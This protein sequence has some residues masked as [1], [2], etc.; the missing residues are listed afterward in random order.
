MIHPI[1]TNISPITAL[2]GLLAENRPDAVNNLVEVELPI[3]SNELETWTD[4]VNQLAQDLQNIGENAI[5]AITFDNIAQLRL[6]SNIGRVDVLGYYTEGDGGGGTFYWDS[7]STDADNGGTS[8]KPTGYSDLVAG[9]WKRPDLLT[10]QTDLFGGNVQGALTNNK[11]IELSDDI[12]ITAPLT[13][14]LPNKINGNDFTILSSSL[15]SY[16]ITQDSTLKDGI[17]ISNITLDADNKNTGN[18]ILFFNKARNTNINNITLE[19]SENNGLWF[20][21]DTSRNKITNNTILNTK[22][23]AIL[24]EGDSTGESGVPTTE[25]CFTWVDRN[26]I[27]DTESQNGI[28][29]AHSLQ[30]TIITNNMLYNIGDCAI[31]V[32]GASGT[33]GVKKAVISNN[34]GQNTSGDN[35]AFIYVRR[36]EHVTANGNVGID[37]FYGIH[38]D[39]SNN[40]IA[41]GNVFINSE[42]SGKIYNSN[43]VSLDYLTQNSISKNIAFIDI[44]N[45]IN[46]SINVSDF[47]LVSQEISLKSNGEINAKTR[48]QP[49]I[50]RTN[51]IGILNVESDDGFMF[52]SEQGLNG[53]SNSLF[54][55]NNTSGWSPVTASLSATDS[56]MTITSSGGFG[57]AD[58][59]IKSG[60]VNFSTVLNLSFQYTANAT[61]A[62]VYVL[63]DG[64]V[65][66]V[67]ALTQT[68][69]LLWYKKKIDFSSFLNKKDIKVRIVPSA[70]STGI[71]TLKTPILARSSKTSKFGYYDLKNMYE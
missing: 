45:G 59:K 49:I 40:V 65:V 18:S 55:D 30:D 68:G 32:G 37:N 15:V 14:S 6:N 50:T 63:A 48:V 47:S 60:V 26:F 64:D 25:N 57:Y 11:N 51:N 19:N 62:L 53:I 21:D 29:I 5:N 39:T 13:L 12:N 10:I 67:D 38:C 61:D 3:L 71:V 69:S 2:P 22:F 36:S 43:N 46:N 17:S 8:I 31:E 28:F 41:K 58:S 56:V 9:R 44:T 16:M 23:N 54:I 66:S 52:L 35:G 34:I 4:E 20:F 27:S 1:E 33:Y 24:V 42:Y 70:S 7:T